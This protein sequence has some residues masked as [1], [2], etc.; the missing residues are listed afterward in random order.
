VRSFATS[1]LTGAGVFTGFLLVE[2][3]RDPTS[4]LRLHLAELA[5]RLREVTP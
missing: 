1:L 2:Q 3:L 5:D 4:S